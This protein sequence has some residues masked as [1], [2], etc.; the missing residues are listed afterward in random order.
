MLTEPEYDPLDDGENLIVPVPDCP[1]ERLN[2]LPP[3]RENPDPITL[4]LPLSVPV[5]L[6]ELRMVTVRS[7]DWPTL[8][9]PKSIEVGVMT[10]LIEVPVCPTPLSGTEEGLDVLVAL[11]VMLTEPE[12]DPLDDGENLTVTDLP[13]PGERLKE[14]PPLVME[15]PEPLTLTLPVSVPVELVELLMFTMR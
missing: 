13:N 8:T 5:E 10:I 6:E 14:P 3:M 2:E 9:E 7:D 4:T 12:Y 1:G 15:N 11:C